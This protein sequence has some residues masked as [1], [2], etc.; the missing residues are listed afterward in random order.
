M[1][2]VTPS[3]TRSLAKVA[4]KL[5]PV[6]FCFVERAVVVRTRIDVP[7]GRTSGFGGAGA[8][9]A[10]VNGREDS[11]SFLEARALR[12]GSLEACVDD[13]DDGLDESAPVSAGAAASDPSVAAA[14][15][16]CFLPHPAATSADASAVI[17][18]QFRLLLNMFHSSP[19]FL[20]EREPDMKVL[21]SLYQIDRTCGVPKTSFHRR[22]PGI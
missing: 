7:A 12:F 22:G 19:S 14:G 8:S 18:Y 17:K 10:G 15:V 11:R 4:V 2:T 21:Q 13:G 20:P 16:S 5:S 9:D 1:A 3:C 6:W